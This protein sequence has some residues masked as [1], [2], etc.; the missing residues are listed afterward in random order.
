MALCVSIQ[1]ACTNNHVLLQEA[2]LGLGGLHGLGHQF[3]QLVLNELLQ[4]IVNVAANDGREQRVCTEHHHQ[5]TFDH[6]QHL[7]QGIAL[8]FVV[9]QSDTRQSVSRT[10]ETIDE[11][12]PYLMARS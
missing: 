12:V 5:H 7:D 10:R 1:C 2:F 6:G 4:L 3:A 11:G 8:F 9:I